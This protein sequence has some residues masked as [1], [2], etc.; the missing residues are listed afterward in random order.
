MIG[1][2]KKISI[3]RVNGKFRIKF[4]GKEN[5]RIL[6][7]LTLAYWTIQHGHIGLSNMGILDCLTLPYWT[8]Q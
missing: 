7:S 5:I 3:K 2:T 8:P 4:I 6:D 1:I